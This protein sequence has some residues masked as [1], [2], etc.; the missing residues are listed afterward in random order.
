LDEIEPTFNQMAFATRHI[1]SIM[2]EGA[3]IKYGI[4]VPQ[5]FE[6]NSSAGCLAGVAYIAID[7]WGNVRPCSHT[8]TIVGSLLKNSLAELWHGPEM[9]TWRNLMPQECKTCAAYSIC[10]GGCRVMAEIRPTHRDPLRLEPLK[11]FS[12][13]PIELELP[14]NGKPVFKALLREETFGYSIL[15]SGRI[16]VIRKEAKT[17]IDTCNGQTNFAEIAQKYGQSSLD[18]LG[19]MFSK[20]M[21][22]IQ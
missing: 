9:Q 2:R 22:T 20:G 14:S 17:L 11:S 10:H 18:L 16:M 3:P 15:H 21:I 12:S 7:P 8:P 1:E 19:E 13:S 6:P 5:C 4:G